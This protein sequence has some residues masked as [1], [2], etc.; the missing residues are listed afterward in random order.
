VFV[1]PRIAK[2]GEH[3]V[4]H[5]FGD[6][7]AGA[8]DDR[9][10]AAMVRTDHFAQLLG[11]EPRRQCCRTRQVAEY[12]R[13][14]PAFGLRRGRRAGL[15]PRLFASSQRSGPLA[16]CCNGFQELAAIADGDDADVS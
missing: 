14:L 4:A 16:Q 7:P 5:V 13:Q 11:I 8:L 12:H 1:G 15:L 9:G 3:T 6:K 10:D 2:I